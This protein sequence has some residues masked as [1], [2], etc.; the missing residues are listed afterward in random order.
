MEDFYYRELLRGFITHS[1]SNF[2]YRIVN[3]NPVV[4]GPSPFPYD[5][6]EL[7]EFLLNHLQNYAYSVMV[8]RCP[9]L[10]SDQIAVLLALAI[11][12]HLVSCADKATLLGIF[13]SVDQAS[14]LDSTDK[15]TNRLARS[16][17]DRMIQRAVSRVYET[18]WVL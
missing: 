10:S 14:S 7:P 12:R 16:V 15:P 17:V 18:F 9:G 1:G 4:E 3:S 11:G 13:S 6:C 2:K 5:D 8:D